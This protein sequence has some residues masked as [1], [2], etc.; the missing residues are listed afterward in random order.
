MR[1]S[2]I[3]NSTLG[4]VKEDSTYWAIPAQSQGGASDS[5]GGTKYLKLKK[6]IL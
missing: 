5:D 1:M 2:D 6:H 4:R 3:W